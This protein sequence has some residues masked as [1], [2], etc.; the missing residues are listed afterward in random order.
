MVKSVIGVNHQGLRDWLIQR[1]SALVMAIYTIGIVLYIAFQPELDYP[2]WYS[3]F[4]HTGMKIATIL[5]LL[6][7]LYHAWIGIW[8]VLTDY[9]KPYLLRLLFNV[10]VLLALVAFFF[11]GLLILWGV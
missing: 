9:V 4:A 2:D 3:L 11:Q 7:L 1:V 5:F 10:I 6:A 8:T